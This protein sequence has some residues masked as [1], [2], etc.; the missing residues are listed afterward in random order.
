MP[1]KRAQCLRFAESPA[2]QRFVPV[3]DASQR[4]PR[5][6]SPPGPRRG[7]VRGVEVS[8]KAL[9]WMELLQGEVGVGCSLAL[10]SHV[11]FGTRRK[12]DNCLLVRRQTLG[13][14]VR[15]HWHLLNSHRAL[16]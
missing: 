8:Q 13:L 12:P 2:L 10:A 7:D 1:Q 16:V 4:A 3:A 11:V 9:G 5:Q 6:S 15:M 14:D